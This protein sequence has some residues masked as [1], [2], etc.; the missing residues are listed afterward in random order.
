VRY[1]A[2]ADALARVLQK[3]AGNV[4]KRIAVGVEKKKGVW[5]WRLRDPWDGDH[6]DD[7]FQRLADHI[8]SGY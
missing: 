8:N 6:W 7:D 3:M 2:E 5:G 4:D 1:W